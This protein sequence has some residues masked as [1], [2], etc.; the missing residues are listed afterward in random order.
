MKLAR[1][2]SEEVSAC[3]ST[4]L[5]YSMQMVHFCSGHLVRGSMSNTVTV[6]ALW[7]P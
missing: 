7:L 2:L 3:K 5:F 1:D 4:K 6:A